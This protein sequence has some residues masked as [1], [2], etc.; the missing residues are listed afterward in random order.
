MTRE[1]VKITHTL[2]LP[3]ITSLF[4]SGF[5]NKSIAYLQAWFIN[6]EEGDEWVELGMTFFPG[7]HNPL[8]YSCFY[9]HEDIKHPQHTTNLNNEICVSEKHE[10]VPLPYPD[11]IYHTPW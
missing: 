3:T 9:K 2:K 10:H 11:I 7:K 8:N 4:S 6:L 5:Q 1:T